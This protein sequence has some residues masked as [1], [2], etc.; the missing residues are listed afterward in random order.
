VEQL[1]PLISSLLAVGQAILE[2]LK[3]LGPIFSA[4]SSIIG[5]AFLVVAWKLNDAV[6]RE[7]IKMAS[8]LVG[9]RGQMSEVSN[10]NETMTSNLRELKIE[11]EELNQTAPRTIEGLKNAM[12][13]LHSELQDRTDNLRTDMA[14]L[15]DDFGQR[16]VRTAGE[17]VASAVGTSDVPGPAPSPGN[18]D[19]IRDLWRDSREDVRLVVETIF[20]TQDGR[21]LRPL[22]NLDYRNYKT[23]AGKL[24]PKWID[25][26]AFESLVGMDRIFKKLRGSPANASETDVTAMKAYNATFKDATNEWLKY[27]QAEPQREAAE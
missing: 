16:I 7:N 10:G 2:E 20:E 22:H 18:F 19:E 9:L 5:I 3:F 6:K 1:L 11:I 27:T 21:T 12:A 15:A 24:Y 4:V 25:N 17:G 23:V 26:D 14:S 13:F 8:N